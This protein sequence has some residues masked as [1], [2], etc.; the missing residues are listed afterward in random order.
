MPTSLLPKSLGDLVINNNIQMHPSQVMLPQSLDTKINHR[1]GKALPAQCGYNHDVLKKP[2][3]AIMA[4]KRAT[5]ELIATNRN[6]AQAR[7]SRKQTL[8]P[9]ATIRNR[10]NVDT[11]CALPQCNNC[12]I[13]S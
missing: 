9:V 10:T 5:D 2:S 3:A 4:S 6:N 1:L 7:I 12:V 13:V 11:R 8:N